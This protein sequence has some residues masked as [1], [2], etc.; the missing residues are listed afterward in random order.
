MRNLKNYEGFKTENGFDLNN[1]EHIFSM[2]VE[3]KLEKPNYLINMGE[4]RLIVEC[5]LCARC[6]LSTLI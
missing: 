3:D 2:Y 6:F 5:W 1:C 4:G